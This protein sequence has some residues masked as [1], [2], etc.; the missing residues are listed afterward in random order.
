MKRTGNGMSIRCWRYSRFITLILQHFNT[1]SSTI[2]I[3]RL[4]LVIAWYSI[5]RSVGAANSRRSIDRRLVASSRS[6]TL[7]SIRASWPSSACG[8]LH[9]VQMLV[10]ATMQYAVLLLLQCRVDPISASTIHNHSR[11]S[12]HCDTNS[13]YNQSAWSIVLGIPHRITILIHTL[14]HQYQGPKTTH[15]KETQSAK[16]RN[17]SPCPRP[18]MAI[19]PVMPTAAA[20]TTTTMAVQITTI[21]L[22]LDKEDHYQR[23]KE[24]YSKR[25]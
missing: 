10:G 21:I 20:T 7:L 9:Y 6:R 24:T 1:T 18:L 22:K 11:K 13:F 17:A 2:L 15:F 25:W 14:P 5:R 8:I 16:G 3:H 19:L 23:R 12:L 4:Y